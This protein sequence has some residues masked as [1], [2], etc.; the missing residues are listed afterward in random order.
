MKKTIISTIAA[1]AI[2]STALQA[3]SYISLSYS[4]AETEYSSSSNKESGFSFGYGIK[5]GEDFKNDL[6]IEYNAIKGDQAYGD[7]YSIHYKLGY[8]IKDF[9]PYATIGYGLQDVGTTTIS[10][11][12]YSEYAT[13][14]SYGVGLTYQV[15]SWLDVDA[16][17]RKF[18][19]EYEIGSLLTIET[20]LNL[21]NV[22][23][24]F[25]F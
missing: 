9:V 19:L 22:G 25:K 3:D 8:N 23:V 14:F 7:M 4:G 15:T 6:G 13:G 16:S 1:L 10:G 24:A 12:D 5:F 2:T 11:K 21:I 17:Y 18:A 20:D